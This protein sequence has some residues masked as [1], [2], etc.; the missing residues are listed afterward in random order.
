MSGKIAMLSEVPDCGVRSQHETRVSGEGSMRCRII[1]RER[2][3]SPSFGARRA[4]SCRRH[5]EC[6]MPWRYQPQR[7]ANVRYAG[8]RER[9]RQGSEGPYASILEFGEQRPYVNDRSLPIHPSTCYPGMGLAE[10][11]MLN[12]TVASTTPNSR[13]FNFL[14]SDDVIDAVQGYVGCC[15][16]GRIISTFSAVQSVRDKVPDC[17]LSDD[18]IERFAVLCAVDQALAVHFDR[19]GSP[20]DPYSSLSRSHWHLVPIWKTK[21]RTTWAL[22]PV[23]RRPR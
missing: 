18:Q 1:V 16:P 14:I 11:E 8:G 19:T 13:Y 22:A 17:E 20:R 12:R 15:G 7:S 6:L 4:G 23:A 9:L 10:G 2:R 21:V 3:L 5:E